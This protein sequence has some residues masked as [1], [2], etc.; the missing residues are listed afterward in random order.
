[1]GNCAGVFCQ[2][3]DDSQIIKKVDKDNMQKALA[4]N[5]E[6]NEVQLN[7]ASDQSNH[8]NGGSIQ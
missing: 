3:V 2:C 5:R 1:M 6:M 7:A 4:A 8:F